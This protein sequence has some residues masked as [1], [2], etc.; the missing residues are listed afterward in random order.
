[1][2]TYRSEQV[3][4]NNL[5]AVADRLGMD[6]KQ[7]D[8]S[9]I[10]LL[11][12]FQLFKKGSGKT[13]FNVLRQDNEELNTRVFI[14]DYQYMANPGKMDPLTTQ[15]VLF[16]D[17]R[18]LSLP[19]FKMKPEKGIHKLREKIGLIQDIDFETYPEFS[20]HY[21]VQGEDED[22]IRR[23]FNDQLLDFFTIEKDW[24]FE[25]VNFHFVLYK[26]QQ[27]IKFW[28]IEE[29]YNKLMKI[30]NMLQS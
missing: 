4:S 6:F 5:I 16:V 23:I 12:D 9:Y 19:D 20:D 24:H 18:S 11:Q 13:V 1:M 29:F 8:D 17:S 22:W 26:Y 30:V 21:L 25:G 27:R 28:Q 15:T 7:K 3:R 2:A 14:F 10:S